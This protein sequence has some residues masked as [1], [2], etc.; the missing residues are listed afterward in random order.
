MSEIEIAGRVVR[1]GA[2][3]ACWDSFKS[4]WFAGPLRLAELFGLDWCGAGESKRERAA[5]AALKG[6]GHEITVRAWGP[7]VRRTVN[8]RAPKPPRDGAPLEPDQIR[9]IA[10]LFDEEFAEDPHCRVALSNMRGGT[11]ECEPFEMR[12]VE[13]LLALLQGADNVEDV[14]CA[15]LDA[16]EFEIEECDRGVCYKTG[17]EIDALHAEY[18]YLENWLDRRLQ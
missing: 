14:V 5:R 4:R 18:G 7:S 12:M 8:D 3:Y 11:Q 17:A 6:T 13:S 16:L 1:V 10:A 9:R 2:R 15:R